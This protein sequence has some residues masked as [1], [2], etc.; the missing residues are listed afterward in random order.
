LKKFINYIPYIL[1][2]VVYIC[3]VTGMNKLDSLEKVRNLSKKDCMVAEFSPDFSQKEK[4]F[5]RELRGKK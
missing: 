2:V 4:E 1:F 5:C 3:I